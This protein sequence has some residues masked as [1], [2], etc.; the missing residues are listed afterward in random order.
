MVAVYH[1]RDAYQPRY[2]PGTVPLNT[3]YH[4]SLDGM[5]L[6]CGPSVIK[7]GTAGGGGLG[8]AE[9]QVRCGLY[10]SRVNPTQGRHHGHSGGAGCY[11]SSDKHCN[12]QARQKYLPTLAE[13]DTAGA[14]LTTGAVAGPVI[15]T[16]ITNPTISVTDHDVSRT[17]AYSCR[18]RC[19]V[20]R[21][22]DK[23]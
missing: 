22:L 8:E 6:R 10:S 11:D 19:E 1:D 14:A 13:A 9:S 7:A 4:R 18:Y 2:T 5:S 23:T 16:L 3:T 12:S 20:R 21:V 15:F 17:T